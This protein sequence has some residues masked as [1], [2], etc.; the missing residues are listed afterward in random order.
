[1]IARPQCPLRLWRRQW[2]AWRSHVVL[3]LLVQLSFVT[4]SL[5][6]D[7][8]VL[9]YNIY[10]RPFFHDGQKIR[11]EYLVGQLSGY[12][13]IVFQEVFDDEIRGLL[14]AGLGT[15]YRFRTHI[16]GEDAGINQDGGVIILSKW[17]I[18]HESQR[19]FTEG[20]PSM[21]WC[22]GPGCCQGLDCYAKKGVVYALINKLGRCYHLFGTH[23]QSGTENWELRNE[24]FSIIKNFIKSYQIRNNEPV[25]IAGDMNVDRYDEARFAEMRAILKA[26]QPKLR[27]TVPPTEGTIYTFDGPGNDLNDNET[28]QRYVD[29]VLYSV[30]HLSPIRAF[31]QVR[32]I[33]SPEPWKQYFWQDWHVDLSD[34][35]AVLGHFDYVQNPNPSLACRK[36]TR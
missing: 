13:A 1:M 21:N 4:S 7:F 26:E 34:H 20:S 32:I 30:D 15:E 17:P 12:D 11:T 19:V 8:D 23:V 5:A 18:I 29:Y 33:R 35:Y 25:I 10:M 2:C 24:Q 27:P 3:A 16:L 14:L 36:P 28:V 31:N 9:S 6:D 22:P